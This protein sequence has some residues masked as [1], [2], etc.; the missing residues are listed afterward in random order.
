MCFEE[1]CKHG[2]YCGCKDCTRETPDERR[3]R[4]ENDA[5]ENECKGNLRMPARAQRKSGKRLVAVK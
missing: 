1:E 4:E 2:I 5:E 3:A